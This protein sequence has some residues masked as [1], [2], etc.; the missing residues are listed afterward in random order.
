MPLCGAILYA[1]IAMVRNDADAMTAAIH[2]K[3]IAIFNKAIIL[4]LLNE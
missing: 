1:H 2:I 4:F 3:A